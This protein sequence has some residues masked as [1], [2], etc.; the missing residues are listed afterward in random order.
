MARTFAVKDRQARVAFQRFWSR[1]RTGRAGDI[2]IACALI[3][4]TLPLMAILALAI[5]CDSAG[6]VF[7]RQERIGLGG[8]HIVF[9][10]FRTTVAGLNRRCGLG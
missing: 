6:P 8:H 5:K 1:D 9:F 4:F 7:E 2:A 10:R 3:A